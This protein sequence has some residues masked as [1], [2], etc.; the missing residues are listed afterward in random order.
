MFWSIFEGNWQKTSLAGLKI[1]YLREILRITLN[2]IFS[3]RGQKGASTE[4]IFWF[5]EKD[6]SQI[7]EIAEILQKAE[8]ILKMSQIQI[9]KSFQVFLSIFAGIL[10][11]KSPEGLKIDYLW[12][13]LRITEKLIFYNMFEEE[14]THGLKE[15]T[16]FSNLR[17]RKILSKTSSSNVPHTVKLSF[18]GVLKHFHRKLKK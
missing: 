18:S 5:D 3:Q 13:K 8:I 4:E 14:Q 2:D 6:I 10:Q 11:K 9:D 7:C 15:T 16:I 17:N 1:D 12:K